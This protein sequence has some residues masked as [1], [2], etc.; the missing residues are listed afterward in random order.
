MAKSTWTVDPAHSSLEFSAKHMMVT[1]VRGQFTQFTAEIEADPTDLTDSNIAF[2]VDVASVDTRNA[3]RDTHLR[4]ADFF[5]VEKYPQMTFKATK[6]ASK[7]HNEYDV[8]G[9]L[10][11]K[12]VT[13]PATFTMTFEGQH[14]DP[15]GNE[16]A[17]FTGEA[18]LS[19][20]DWG[21]TWNV[22]L[23]AGGVLVSDQIKVTLD[24]QA[25]KQA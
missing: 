25:A 14:K 3:D 6:I 15:W 16:K 10:T 2:T 24:I 18:K 20:K 19:R 12:D 11:I 8:T 7:G 23:E 1:T 22:A 21:L 5:D 9:D 17:G 4:S 13:H